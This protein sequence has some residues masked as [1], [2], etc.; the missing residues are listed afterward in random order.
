MLFSQEIITKHELHSMALDLLGK[1]PDLLVPAPPRPALPCPALPCPA[2]PCPACRAQAPRSNALQH[3]AAPPSAL[4]ELPGMAALHAA[5]AACPRRS[6]CCRATCS[7]LLACC[8][9]FSSADNYREGTQQQRHAGQPC[10]AAPWGQFK[11]R[12]VTAYTAGLLAPGF[13]IC[14]HGQPVCGSRHEG[15]QGQGAGCAEPETAGPEQLLVRWLTQGCA[16]ARA[17]GFQSFS[18]S[19]NRRNLRL[20]VDR[21]RPL[22]MRAG[23]LPELHPEVRVHAV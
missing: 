12:G 16:R 7:M 20:A 3:A 6:H 8:R 13:G 18:N 21:L 9:S 23:G 11:S 10:L 4:Q 5:A 1:S 19:S 14:R 17:G 15:L 2:L 22:R